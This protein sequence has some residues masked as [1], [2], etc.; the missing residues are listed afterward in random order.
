[1]DNFQ[2]TDEI[3]EEIVGQ[4]H[5]DGF[6]QQPLSLHDRI[7]KFKESKQ[8]KPLFTTEDGVEIFEGNEYWYIMDCVNNGKW[9]IQKKTAHGTGH[10]SKHIRFSTK[11][12]AE[13]YILM[14]KPCLSLKDVVEQWH[15]AW[16]AESLFEK[17]TMFHHY[18]NFVKSKL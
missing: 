11:E 10:N 5:R 6:H 14:N 15:K 17:S 3:I 9:E 7:E 18:K 12:T 4:A 2:W 1:M 13:E 16:G 8:P